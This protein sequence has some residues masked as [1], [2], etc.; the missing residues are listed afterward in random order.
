MRSTVILTENPAGRCD[1]RPQMAGIILPE[2][3]D[4][5]DKFRHLPCAG[6]M[7]QLAICLL[8]RQWRASPQGIEEGRRGASM[9]L[10]QRSVE[11]GKIYG[12]V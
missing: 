7:E 8:F 9:V 10:R 11:K 6:A 3:N 2:G 12:S 4:K 5:F 1:A